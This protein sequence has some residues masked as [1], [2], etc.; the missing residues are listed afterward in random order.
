MRDGRKEMIGMDEVTTQTI[1]MDE[2]THR[3]DRDVRQGRLFHTAVHTLGE[4]Q[5]RCLSPFKGTVA[6]V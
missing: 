4:E 3:D 2:V 6:A 1:G 5:L